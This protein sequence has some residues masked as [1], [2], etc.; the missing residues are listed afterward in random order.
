[1]AITNMTSQKTNSHQQHGKCNGYGLIPVK[2][3]PNITEMLRVSLMHN[4]FTTTTKKMG[5]TEMLKFGSKTC[6]ACKEWLRR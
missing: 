2:G 1:M 4:G 3:K 6:G 5:T